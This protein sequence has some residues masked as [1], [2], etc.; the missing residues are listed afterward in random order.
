MNVEGVKVWVYNAARPLLVKWITRGIVYGA[1]AITASIA[2]ES[3]GDDT[4]TKV[5]QWVAAVVLALIGLGIDYL[6]NRIDKDQGNA[7]VLAK[8]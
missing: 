3:P 8:K 5:S 1:S 6:H 2:V 4:I 7:K